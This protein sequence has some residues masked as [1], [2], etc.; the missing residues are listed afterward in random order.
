MGSRCGRSPKTFWL[1]SRHS[2]A[3]GRSRSCPGSGWEGALARCQRPSRLRLQTS[4]AE[5]PG[6]RD[7]VGASRERLRGSGERLA[8][9]PETV[10]TLWADAGGVW[11]ESVGCQ[12][13]AAQHLPR[14]RQCLGRC[15]AG[16]RQMRAG[17]RQRVRRVWRDAA[18]HVGRG[19]AVSRE[20]GL[21]AWPLGV[22]LVGRGPTLG[23]QRC[24]SGVR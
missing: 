1:R 5:L 13:E 15:S 3:R 19:C 2:P 22:G 24:R 6:S 7:R 18:A 10:S 17:G 23:V 4:R 20:V 14:G 11:R 8:G 16:S 9:S 12:R 21:A